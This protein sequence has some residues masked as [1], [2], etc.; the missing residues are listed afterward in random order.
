[1]GKYAMLL[2]GVVTLASAYAAQVAVSSARMDR[3]LALLDRGTQADQ[4]NAI[5]YGGVLDPITVE[6]RRTPEGALASGSARAEQQ[7]ARPHTD[8]SRNL[9]TSPENVRTSIG[10]VM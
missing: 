5:W 10:L 3:A 4:P 6:A 1:M 2:G 9:A 8:H 7:P